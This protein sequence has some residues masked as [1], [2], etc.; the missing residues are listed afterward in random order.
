MTP[1]LQF[2]LTLVVIITAAK[3]AGL[4]SSRLGQPA[5]LGELL[6][7]LILGPTVL[8]ILHWP[9]L[10]SESLEAV[11][12]DLAELGVLFLMFIAGLEV[13][14]DAMRRA[15]RPALWAGLLGV[16]TPLGMS[17]VLVPL[18]FDVEHA[19]FLGLVLAAT[20]VSISAQTLIELGVLRSRV[21]MALLGAAVVDDVLVILALSLF[22][23]LTDQAGGGVLAVVIILAR[24]IAFGGL[25]LWLAWRYLQRVGDWTE[26]LA[27]SEPIMTLAVVVTLGYGW[28]AE[29]VGGV[30][31]ITGTF[32]SGVLFGRTRFKG[33]IS[34]GIHTLAYAWLVPVFFVSIGLEADLRSLGL[35]HLPLAL[36]LLGV[37]LAS[38]VLGS[39]LGGLAGG[40][41][42]TDALRVGVGMISRGEVGLIVASLG[43]GAGLVGPDLFAIIVLIVLLTTLITPVLLRA[44]YSGGSDASPATPGT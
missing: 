38:K 22:T 29:I 1:F 34:P 37:A 24:M 44:A 26:R 2:I 33:R 40:L 27:I 13:E 21:G 25:G 28:M 15:G 23:A 7:G 10:S 18:G 5:V 11:I 12:F 30:A 20:S 39:G 35:S 41:S 14:L 19:L 17:M 16:I 42:R 43:L 3:G 4:L 32:M 8:N 9:V 6:I 36:L 31:A